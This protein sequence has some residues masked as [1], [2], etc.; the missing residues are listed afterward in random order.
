MMRTPRYK[1]CLVCAKIP[2]VINSEDLL[3][4]WNN[5]WPVPNIKIHPIISRIK[6]TIKRK[7]NGIKFE[8]P[9]ENLKINES[10]IHIKK[11]IIAAENW[12]RWDL[13]CS[14]PIPLLWMDSNF[15]TLI[16]T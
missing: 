16:L 8:I 7:I 9:V 12:I 1:G 5:I 13:G 2:V 6:H 10:K 15:I 14:F 11:K 4:L 3:S